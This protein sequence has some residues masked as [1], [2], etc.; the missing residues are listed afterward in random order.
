LL[1]WR[2]YRFPIA[3]SEV[4]GMEA[5]LELEVGFGDGRYTVYRAAR[6]PKTLFVGLEISSASVARALRRVKDAGVGNVRIVKV[7]AEFAVQ[8]LFAPASLANITVNFPDPWPKERHAG[9]RLL[10]APFFELAASRLKPGGALR[11]ATDHEDYLDFAKR[12]AGVTGRYALEAVD[13]PEAVFETKYALKWKAQ[14]KGLYYQVF[15]LMGQLQKVYPVVE[16]YAMPHAILSGTLPQTLRFQKTV[17]EYGGG[18]VV[19]LELSRTLG[20]EELGER[21]LFRATISEPGLQQQV[22]VSVR[23]KAGELVVGLESF[24]DPVVTKAVKGAVHAVV[25]W[26]LAQSPRLGLKQASY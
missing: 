24:G 14:S 1:L 15:R 22:I 12:E 2:N 6:E 18:H 4:F 7:N 8:H 13:P 21:L 25:G 3:W 20:P 17:T 19:L 5:D 10:R 23:A 11:L 26:L 16:N 9:N